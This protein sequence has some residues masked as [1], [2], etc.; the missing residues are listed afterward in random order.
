MHRIGR[1]GRAEE[2]GKE[3]ISFFHLQDRQKWLKKIEHF[4]YWDSIYTQFNGGIR[5]ISK[6]ARKLQKK[7]ARILPKRKFLA[8][9]E[10]YGG[11]Q[12]WTLTNECVS[13]VIE[14]IEHNSQFRRFYRFTDVPNELVFQTIILNSPFKQNV[15]NWNDYSDVKKR[16]DLHATWPCPASVYNFRYIDWTPERQSGS[17]HPV[18]FEEQDFELLKSSACLFAR[19]FDS[20]KSSA[21]LDR[22][23]KELL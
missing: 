9:M 1:T 4:Y 15:M 18:V 22:I 5:F 19:K 10:P 13:Y 8:E 21:L 20:K 16:A 7:F 14:Y 3:F 11:S 17:G 12:W 6:R 2:K 23:D